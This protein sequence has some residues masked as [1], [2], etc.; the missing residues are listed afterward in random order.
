[1]EKK[2]LLKELVES[3]TH[4]RTEFTPRA[5][6]SDKGAQPIGEFWDA[7]KTI[8]V[9][10]NGAHQT[11]DTIRETDEF[12]HYLDDVK[13]GRIGWDN[14]NLV[15]DVTTLTTS[16][17]N[18]LESGDT[19]I[20]TTNGEKHSYIVAYKKDNKMSL[21]YTDCKVVKE[22][23][24]EKQNG[25]WTYIAINTFKPENYY[26]KT[27]VDDKLDDI[28]GIDSESIEAIKSIVD[29]LNDETGILPILNSK[30]EKL[31]SGTNI[32]TISNQSLIGS[33]NIIISYNDLSNK[34]TI[35]TVP[36][37]VSS[38]TN[39]SGYLTSADL[40]SIL[41]RISALEVAAGITNNEE[42]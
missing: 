7:N 35:P 13:T 9:I 19:V 21:V 4:I 12:A 3:G 41:A 26:T 37:N 25:N 22:V 27:Q 2:V 20:E 29:D 18:E 39:D 16:Q 11:H 33:G 31:V 17:I 28:L 8:D 10:V 6:V 34:P 1:M 15:T 40:T 24:Y 42:P 30:Q 32:K 5:V 23:H 36:T 38:F 14:N